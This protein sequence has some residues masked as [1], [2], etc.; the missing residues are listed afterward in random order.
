MP[1]APQIAP[2][3]LGGLAGHYTIL[4]FPSFVF[5]L[6]NIHVGDAF[7]TSALTITNTAAS[8][9]TNTYSG[10]SSAVNWELAARV[11]ISCRRLHLELAS[12]YPYRATF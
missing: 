9:A 1:P 11:K 4:P 7:G 5:S 6:T 10:G 12:A 8:G 3:A 2:S